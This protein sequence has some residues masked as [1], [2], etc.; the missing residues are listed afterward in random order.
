MW[1]LGKYRW[2]WRDEQLST[3]QFTTTLWME[4]KQVLRATNFWIKGI[5]A[6]GT[7]QIPY[8]QPAAE[9]KEPSCWKFRFQFSIGSLVHFWNGERMKRWMSKNCSR[10]DC[11]R[12]RTGRRKNWNTKICSTLAN[13]DFRMASLHASGLILDAV[14]CPSVPVI[15]AK[16]SRSSQHHHQIFILLIIILHTNIN[17]MMGRWVRVVCIRASEQMDLA[18]PQQTWK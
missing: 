9:A 15:I 7:I 16:W 6:Q 3:L 17:S 5:T 13:V 2:L 10:V 12:Q 18:L 1:R 14:V 8:N 11:S 4:T